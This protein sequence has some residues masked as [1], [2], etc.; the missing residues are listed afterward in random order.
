M[1]NS[2]IVS[3]TELWTVNRHSSW[4][5]AAAALCLHHCRFRAIP[6]GRKPL[7]YGSSFGCRGLFRAVEEIQA[8]AGNS[9]LWQCTD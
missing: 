1:G 8:H 2:C 7:Q 4:L 9:T 3:V 6:L 5:S